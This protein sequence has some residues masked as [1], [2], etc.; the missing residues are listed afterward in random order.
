MEVRIRCWWIGRWSVAEGDLVKGL[1]TSEA[2]SKVCTC[3][4]GHM[5]AH[6]TQGRLLVI[7]ISSS[8][9]VSHSRLSK[10]VWQSFIIQPTVMVCEIVPSVGVC[11][12]VYFVPT[13]SSGLFIRKILCVVFLLV[14]CMAFNSVILSGALYC[15]LCR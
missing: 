7:D 10:S 3:N 5:E 9:E 12:K 4:A 14:T 11:L 15:V 13:Q 1:W 8:V 2:N 6:S